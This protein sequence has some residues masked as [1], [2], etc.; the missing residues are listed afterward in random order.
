MSAALS[1]FLAALLALATTH[2]LLDRARLV[3][4]AARLAGCGLPAASLLLAL[5]ACAEALAGLALL[6][7]ELRSGGAL[8]AGLIWLGYGALLARRR[9][10]TLDCGCDLLPRE[11]PVDDF[12]IARPLV[13]VLLALLAGLLPGTS[14]SIDTPFAALAMLALWFAAAELQAI[15]KL[16]RI[17]P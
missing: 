10:E 3:P 9:G 15:P 12:A 6:M 1:L 11:R 4:V 7:A 8:A 14:W 17:R 13:L 5:A 2:K 16:A